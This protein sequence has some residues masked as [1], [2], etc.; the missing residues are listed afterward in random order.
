MT[1]STQCGVTEELTDS[2]DETGTASPPTKRRKQ[3]VLQYSNTLLKRVKSATY[4][5]HHL[6]QAV[7]GA[8]VAQ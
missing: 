4:A 8:A 2:N 5:H 6:A 1:D 3:K 7:T